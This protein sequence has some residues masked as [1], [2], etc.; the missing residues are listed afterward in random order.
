[1]ILSSLFLSQKDK[2]FLPNG[3]RLKVLFTLAISFFILF[4]GQVSI[5]RL[6]VLKTFAELEEEKALTDARR[7][8][9]ALLEKIDK[10]RITASDWAY[11]NDTY[12]FVQDKNAAYIESNLTKEVFE[13]LGINV[14][15]IINT[16]GEIIFQNFLD[17]DNSENKNRNMVPS[18]Y[19]KTFRDNNL[20]SNNY[21]VNKSISGL[22]KSNKKG[23]LLSIEPILTTSEKGPPAG[24]IIMGRF[25]DEEIIQE[26]EDNVQIP[27]SLYD[28]D[29]FP[30]SNS[31]KSDVEK[32]LSLEK[33]FAIEILNQNNIRNCVL[34]SDINNNPILVLEGQ[35]NRALY[36]RGLATFKFY[37]WSTLIIGLISVLI[38]LRIVDKLILSRLSYLSKQVEDIGN[39]DKQHL[40][41]LMT[42]NDEISNLANVINSTMTQLEKK[43]QELEKAKEEADYANQAKSQFLANM[44]HELRTPLNAILGFNQIM[45]HD[46]S[47]KETQKENLEIVNRS[48]KYLLSLINDILDLSKIESGKI[49]LNPNH[50]RLDEL[51]ESIYN[52]LRLKAEAKGLEFSYSINSNVPQYLY[53]DSKKLHQT[54][55]NLLGN[56]IKFTA[57]GKVSLLVSKVDNE[58]QLKT[59]EKVS[60][61][62]ILFIVEDTGMGID[63]DELDNL[64]EA[65]VQT[66]S[67]K[68]SNQ[69]T[70]LGLSISRQFVKLMGGDIKVSSEWGK[71]T[72]FQFTIKAEIS[73]A[74]KVKAKSTTS[75]V[76]RLAPSQPNYRIL[77][78]DDVL[79]NRYL[80]LKLLEPIGFS[81]KLAENGQE[82]INIWREWY[83]HL[84]WMDMQMP[85]VNGYEATKKIKS[86][87]H[88]KKT[89]IIA[90]TASSLEEEKSFILSTGCD[91][92]VSKPFEEET[93]FAKIAQHLGV[94]YLYQEDSNLKNDSINFNLETFILSRESLKVM[95]SKWRED[96]KEAAT[97]LDLSSLENLI[98]EIPPQHRNLADALLEKS[99]NFDFDKIIELID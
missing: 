99:H 34:L 8:E 59:K 4:L 79:E 36:N 93:I 54:L 21:P 44:S 45:Q 68:K 51:V 84:I 25:L 77:V 76:I 26:I 37:F 55:M 58:S 38:I 50:F 52:L 60:F 83:P 43:K 56:A 47:I 91:D 10:V 74:A 29:D 88:G 86:Q 89:I 2:S 98:S 17:L 15:F 24:R 69:G 27:I 81:V 71:G 85:V 95:P 32:N 39:L 3:I 6:I 61:T 53:A 28:Y 7:I 94:N 65:F 62:N 48:G 57:K 92:F 30:L 66:Q 67:G 41:V 40:S 31:A 75:K 90:L 14:F 96:V 64:F 5:A 19:I 9:K 46:A 73:S 23:I 49:T 97:K 12:Q 1:M 70:G 82:A 72:T 87:N 63:K 16:N 35:K 18:Q 80:M 13:T 11:W 42:D 20:I 78:V 22:L 33:K